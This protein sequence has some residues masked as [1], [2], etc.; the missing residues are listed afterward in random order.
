MLV[1]RSVQDN[2]KTKKM[3]NCLEQ[4]T[5][6]RYAM[7][8]LIVSALSIIPMMAHAGEVLDRIINRGELRVCIWPDY[9]G[10]TFRNPH[11]R[12]LQGIDIELSRAFAQDLGVKLTYVDSSFTSLIEDVETDRCD[13][14]MFAVGVLPQRAA[15]LAF[16]EPYL[17]SDIYGITTQ[18]QR[19]INNWDDIDRPGVL[20]GVQ[21]GTFMEPVMRERLKQ[22]KLVVIRPPMLRERELQ[23]GRIDVFMTDYPY[24]RRLLDNL[25]WIRLVAPST[26]YHV[27]PYAYAVKQGDREWLERVNMFVRAIKDDG[28]LLQAAQKFGLTAIVVR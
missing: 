13:I 3:L 19:M 5:M 12:A 26:P 25:D 10:V 2:Q 4:S 23:A 22:A 16:S 1:Y 27:L 18:S 15:R 6:R 20:V 24:S 28:R 21:A 8:W 7:S 17:R 14:A 9:Y 11:T